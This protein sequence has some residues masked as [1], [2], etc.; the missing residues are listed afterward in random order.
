MTEALGEFVFGVVIMFGLLF[1]LIFIGIVHFV[2]GRGWLVSSI[3][4]V[5]GGFLV[6]FIFSPQLFDAYLGLRGVSF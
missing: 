5:V 2:M 6:S 3:A 4:G 1:S